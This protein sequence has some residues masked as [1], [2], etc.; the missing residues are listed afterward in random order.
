MVS[1]IKGLK[2]VGPL[3][4]TWGKKFEYTSKIPYNPKASGLSGYPFTGK[5]CKVYVE[6]S[7]GNLGLAPNP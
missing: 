4:S 7:Y 3:N 6:F 5:Q 2:R 1:Y